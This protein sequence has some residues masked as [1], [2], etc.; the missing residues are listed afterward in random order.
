GGQRRL[1]VISREEAVVRAQ[2]ALDTAVEQV[3]TQVEDLLFQLED[4]RR[5]VEMARLEVVRAELELTAAERQLA[6]P[7][8]TATADAVANARR[9]VKRAEISWREAVWAYQSRWLEL[10]ILQGA[11]DWDAL[12]AGSE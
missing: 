12:R 6:L 3:R 8:P 10:G 1:S 11:V 7:V 4:A 9:A 2:E 5:Q